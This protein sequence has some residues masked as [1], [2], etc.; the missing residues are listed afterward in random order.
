MELSEYRKM[1]FRDVECP[2][3]ATATVRR[4]NTGDYLS[5][6]GSVPGLN[7]LD[8]KHE[9]GNAKAEDLKKIHVFSLT[10]GVVEFC[11]GVL[12]DKNTADCG[13]NELSVHDVTELDA[14][15]LMGQIAELTNPPARVEGGLPEGASF[16]GK[17]GDSTNP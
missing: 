1:V 16:S 12:V 13:E 8:G 17:H 3:G 6:M 5:V 7:L 2:S 4:L 15:Y 9:I 11:G 14:A 10:R